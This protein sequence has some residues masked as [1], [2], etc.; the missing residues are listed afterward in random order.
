LRCIA[1][2]EGASP[3]RLQ[4][5]FH[6]SGEALHRTTHRPAPP[7]TTPLIAIA[8]ALHC[9]CEGQ[10]VMIPI[11]LLRSVKGKRAFLVVVDAL[12]GGE[13]KENWQQALA[14]IPSSMQRRI[15]ALVSDDH[16]SL[17]A[18][19]VE[20]GWIH[21]VCTFHVKARFH[22]Y[23]PRRKHV[24][25]E[26]ERCRVWEAAKTICDDPNPRKVRAAIRTLKQLGRCSGFPPLLQKSV[27]GLSREWRMC[28]TYM[29]HPE[30]HLPATSNAVESVGSR[31]REML[32]KRR[33]FRTLKSLRKW[34]FLFQKVYPCVT[35]NGAGNLQN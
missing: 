11:I 22:R 10:S 35:C 3:D 34:L 8:D 30:L 23:L 12:P 1:Q 16:P 26:R 9:D 18:R 27:R 31:V 33:G 14:Q 29:E 15:V 20:R 24:Q 17:A 2:R 21:Q 5:R 28:R 25:S 4:R 7:S 19:A 13:S 6:Q 32:T